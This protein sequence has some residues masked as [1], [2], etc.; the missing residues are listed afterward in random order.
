MIY[1]ELVIA[2]ITMYSG[3]HV[4]TEAGDVFLVSDVK[5]PMLV[6]GGW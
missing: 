1:E 4:K 6:L 5:G 2:P 3:A